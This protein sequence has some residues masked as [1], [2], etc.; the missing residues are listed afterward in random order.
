[1]RSQR[2][3]S[4]SSQWRFQFRSER[5]DVLRHSERHDLAYAKPAGGSANPDRCGDFV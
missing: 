3:P 5:L 4:K 1:M 2:K